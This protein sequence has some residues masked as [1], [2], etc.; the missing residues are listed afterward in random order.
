MLALDNIEDPPREVL[1]WASAHW[2]EASTRLTGRLEE[3]AAGGRDAV[4]G[5]EAFY[6]AHL[7]GEKGETR[8]YPILCR[9]IA[10]DRGIAEWLDDAVTETL[11]GILI[12]VFDGD[13][14]PLRLAIESAEGDEFARASALAALGFLVR[15]R[16]A[17]SDRDMRVYLRRIRRDMAPRRASVLWMTW[18]ST[19]ASLGYRN[20]R[21]EVAQLERDGYLP[22]SDFNGEEFDVRIELAKSDAAGLAAFAYDF[23]EPLQDATSALLSL[24]GAEVAQA[25]RRLRGVA[26]QKH[27]SRF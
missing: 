16:R 9:L 13:T 20:M 18:A 14:I 24:A 7:C 3:F 1:S 4:S 26:A 21:S 8:T 22:D 23:V 19:V 10:E 12:R 15:A 5:A 2:D 6:I 11:P 27:N 17:V 25:A